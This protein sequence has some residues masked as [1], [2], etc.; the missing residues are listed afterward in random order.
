M[1]CWFPLS[2]HVVWRGVPDEKDGDGGQPNVDHK[3][4]VVTR[5]GPN[6]RE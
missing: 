4:L 5:L 6:L 2:Q 3:I 1:S